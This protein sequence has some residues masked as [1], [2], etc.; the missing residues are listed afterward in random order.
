MAIIVSTSKANSE[1]TSNLVGLLDSSPVRT[2]LDLASLTDQHLAELRA[3]RRPQSYCEQ[4]L[5]QQI[6]REAAALD[7]AH[8]LEVASIAAVA[9]QGQVSTINALRT[10]A[11][12]GLQRYQE[13]HHRGFYRALRELTRQEQAAATLVVP[14][15]FADEQACEDYLLSWQQTQTWNCP[16]CHDARRY[17][18]SKRGQFECACGRQFAST[19][20]TIYH[21]SHAPLLVWFTAIGYVLCAP[22]VSAGRIAAAVGMNR[23]QTVSEIKHKVAAALE[24][25]DAD[26]LL[27]GVNGLYADYRREV[28]SAASSSTPPF[29][30]SALFASDL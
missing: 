29:P 15:L 12:A 8:Q 10:P 30:A 19:T 28:L 25:D 1:V 14:T 7:V 4:L 24:A 18:L 26:R 2:T 16:D 3:D 5:Q 13:I 11:M 22:Q 23:T 17:R 27:A 6:A 9:A 21:G 20:G